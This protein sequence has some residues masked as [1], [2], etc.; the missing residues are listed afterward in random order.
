[1][2]ILQRLR[3][4]TICLLTLAVPACANN[5]P[6]PDGLPSV[7]LV[8]PVAIIAAR[9]AR[10]P[11][12]KRSVPTRILYG[13]VMLALLV[14]LGAGD[15]I[16]PLAALGV[17]VYSLVRAIRIFRDSKGAKPIILGSAVILFSV[18]AVVDYV[19]SCA[20][21]VSFMAVHESATVGSLRSITDAELE[22]AKLPWRGKRESSEPAS[23]K[24][25]EGAGLLAPRFSGGR[26]VSGYVYGEFRDADSKK[27]VIYAVPAPGQKVST[28]FQ[29][30][31]PSNSLV[32]A[33][34][35]RKE[36]D[37]GT[38]T[39][40]FAVDETGVIRYVVRSTSAPPSRDEIAQRKPLQ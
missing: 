32:R 8:F 33:L 24:E 18:F 15:E 31:I 30:L 38:G 39:R 29:D 11:P 26:I 12:V 5:P 4:L 14:V 2:T 37:A 10:V 21:N 13:I 20:T 1:M 25:L 23:L 6:Q 36:E 9:L 35:D 22:F 16:G 7:L 27:Y 28:P 17:L 19:I 3:L 40:S 34:L